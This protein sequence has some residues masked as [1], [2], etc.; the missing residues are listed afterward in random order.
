MKQ[1]I[2]AVIVCLAIAMTVVPSA[3][4]MAKSG[5][6]TMMY[7]GK[8]IVMN[9]LKVGDDEPEPYNFFAEYKDVKKAFGQPKEYYPMGK[10]RAA[11][12]RFYKY[13]E[14]GFSFTFYKWNDKSYIGGLDINIT[15]KKAA[16]NGRKVGMSKLEKEYG[17]SFVKAAKQ[18]NKI[19]LEYL[20]FMPT[21]YKFQG[22]KVSKMH[23]FC[24]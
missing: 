4:V 24:S 12:Q 3:T 10:E 11:D 7:K 6:M 8:T 18:K 13:K 23:F 19:E 17:K 20:D 14:K 22:G 1:R 16:L 2:I 21:V 9:S 15:S 5:N